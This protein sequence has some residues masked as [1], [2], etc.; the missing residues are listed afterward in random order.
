[1]IYKMKVCYRWLKANFGSQRGE[2]GLGAIVSIAI[3]LIITSFIIL[4]NLETFA[5]GMM[6]DMQNWWTNTVSQTLFPVD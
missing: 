1:M 2:F 5:S 6:T 3:G 4:P